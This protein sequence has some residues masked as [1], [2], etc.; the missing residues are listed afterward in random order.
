MWIIHHFEW[1]ISMATW[2]FWC[3]TILHQNS[4]KSE[5]NLPFLPQDLVTLAS[6]GFR[7]LAENV[8][9]EGNAKRCIGQ[10]CPEEYMIQV[11]QGGRPKDS[12]IHCLLSSKIFEKNMRKQ[13]ISQVFNPNFRA[14]NLL[15]IYSNSAPQ[16]AT[17]FPRSHDLRKRKSDVSCWVNGDHVARAYVETK[18]KCAAGRTQPLLDSRYRKPKGGTVN[19]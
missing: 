17:R 10:R 1:K 11:G 2:F 4:T 14:L 16:L 6:A 3:K 7:L 15:A 19:W 5:Q 9:P 8:D 13:Q 12:I 18:G